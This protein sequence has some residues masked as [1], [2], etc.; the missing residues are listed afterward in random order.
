MKIVVTGSNG[1]VGANL[2]EELTKRFPDAEISCLVRSAKKNN[3]GNI[4]NYAVNYLD[5]STL[6]NCPAF[7]S[8]DYFYH[9]AGVT[10]SATEKGFVEGNVI[11]GQNILET[12]VEKNVIPKRF[13]LVSSQT[14]SGPSKGQGHFKTETEPENPVELY[15]KSKLESEKTL[16]KFEGKIPYTIISPS[17]VFGP[18]DVDFFN[19]FKMTKSGINV[20]A[21]NKYQSVSLVYVKDLVNAIIDS[22]FSKNTLNKKYFIND[23]EPRNWIEIQSEIFKVSGRNK[24]DFTLPFGLL[25]VLAYGGSFYSKLTNQP[26]LLNLNK[27]QLS[28]PDFWVFS[29]KKAKKDFNFKCDYSFKEAIKETYTWYKENKWM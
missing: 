26:V 7:E 3:N 8:I 18:R 23:D 16:R 4:K 13:I 27:V 17:S 22:G 24:I 29:N 6:F 1:F 19:I 28:K 12:L 15:G 11:P 9:V 14:A 20:Y 2:I 25:K 10:K 21:G 5:K